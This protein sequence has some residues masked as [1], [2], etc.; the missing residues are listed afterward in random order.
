M[1]GLVRGWPAALA[2]LTVALPLVTAV[3]PAAAA[4][5]GAPPSA[6]AAALAE[7]D[8]SGHRVEVGAL[9]TE[10]QEVYAEPDGRL[11][12]RQHV[13]PVRVRR[14]AG[15]A[16]VDTTLRRLP[17]GTVAP[18]AAAVDLKFSGG[19]D[20]ALVSIGKDGGRLALDW[21]GTLPEPVLSGDTATYPGVLPGVDLRLRAE[22]EGFTE[23]L[24]V[25][26]RAAA[27][28]PKLAELRFGARG[29][30]VSVRTDDAGN[31]DVVDGRGRVLFHGPTP[32]MWD[33]GTTAVRTR[34][35]AA[36]EGAR[37]AAMK[38]RARGDVLSLI[39]DAKML[40]DPG[41]RYPVYIDPYLFYAAKK[42]A[43]THV[44]KHFSG[45]SY[46]NN[47]D[48]AKVGYYNDSWSS[49]SSDTY[50]SFFRLDT[51]PLAGRKIYKATFNAYES[52]S[53][54]CTKRGVE[55]WRTGGISNTTTWKKQPAWTSKVATLNAAKGWGDN[56]PAGG[57]DFEATSVVTEAAANAW[58]TV[59][60][61]LRA[62]SESD[63]LGWKK[64]RNNPV[65][66][67][68]YNSLPQVPI[69]LK[70]YPAYACAATEAGAPHV[71]SATPRLMA[72]V[73]DPDGAT[74]SLHARFEVWSGGARVW[75]HATVPK[76]AGTAEA[77]PAAL[78]DD[79]VYAWRVRTEDGL[80]VSEWSGWCHIRIS[81]TAPSALPSAESA[82]YP[83][84]NPDAPK[85]SGG[86]GK[87]GTFTFG[88]NG[89]PD[90]TGYLYDVDNPSPRTRI[91]APAADHRV[92]VSVTPGPSRSW[93]RTLYVRSVDAAGNAGPV[94][95]Y[96]FYVGPATDP[97]GH[98]SFDDGEGGSAADASGHKRTATLYGAA[99]TD[100][101]LGDSATADG[102]Q[103][104]DQA[105][106][107][108]GS[109]A[110]GETSAPSVDTST[111]FTVATW[112]RLR[113]DTANATALSSAGFVN[114][115]FQL[116][117]SSHAR[118]WVFDRHHTDAENSPVSWAVSALPYQVGRWTH[119]T[120]VYDRSAGELRL[121]VNGALAG[122]VP[123]TTPWR[124]V[125]GMQFGRLKA[126]GWLVE[127]FPG[128]IDD[129]R[130]WDRVVYPEEIAGTVNRPA[131]LS[132]HWALDE[133]AGAT[134]ADGS[135][136]GRTATLFGGSGWTGDHRG[137][138]GQAITL[139]TGRYAATAG[140]VVE[141]DRGFSVSAWV[142]RDRD[143]TGTVLCQEGTRACGFALYYSATLR[144]WV[145]EMAAS[146]AEGAARLR[147]TALVPD[148]DPN[149]GRWTHLVGVYDPAARQARLYV[150][151]TLAGAVANPAAW[152]A[153]GPLNIGRVRLPTGYG[154]H[155]AGAVADVR[156]YTGVLSQDEI[157]DLRFQ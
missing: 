63:R 21:P 90:V 108:D 45:T 15:W 137:E 68:E 67:V 53:Y 93:L 105:A 130:V 138:P 144:R 114:S 12:L 131:A 135:G 4:E 38:V 157:D 104:S 40:A 29:E 147:A 115:G 154:E 156:A 55:L 61:G 126:N 101:R 87:P 88:P 141:T 125:G 8:A 44:S 71:A 133:A 13:H 151:G 120:G 77:V 109:A 78:A 7:A 74:Q 140:P 3:A 79:G 99:W 9:R 5:R 139:D 2:A 1:A 69:A 49:P 20:S 107:F 116:H 111:S 27:Q 6:E 34:A 118:A 100:G 72:N 153:A 145:F 35:D 62:S 80:D 60:L 98:W 89:D 46:Y 22:G 143:V 94:L 86:V 124:A 110:Y 16:P 50:R 66:E 57:L 96:D 37:Q 142:R 123:F 121:Y 30:G 119:L 136:Y 23:V 146:E 112:V 106:T 24:V 91:D 56:C 83:P 134:A 103:V 42:T 152:H 122:K 113:E 43:W 117:Y 92:T 129:V 18:V 33:S 148:P 31:I 14:G 52:Y 97:A 39:P 36:P 11:L 95:A 84:A 48:A 59:T 102:G 41:T 54:S 65:L 82:D 17:D 32:T 127:H 149:L 19:G 132:G 76:Q 47:S 75:E 128:E 85:M 26:D 73:A 150:D 10:N 58:P 64:F 25:R 28:S 70:I 155:F 81:L 51:A